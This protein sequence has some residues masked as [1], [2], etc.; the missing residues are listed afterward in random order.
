MHR[1]ES[2][3][4]PEGCSNNENVY[5][6]KLP[7]AI[8]DVASALLHLLLTPPHVFVIICSASEPAFY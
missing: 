8:A 4:F 3:F 2:S 5:F 1:K 7:H 6:K